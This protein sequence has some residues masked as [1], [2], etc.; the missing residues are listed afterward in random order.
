M[1]FQLFRAIALTVVLCFALPAA[2]EGPRLCSESHYYFSGR[3]TAYSLAEGKNG[4]A[5]EKKVQMS[6]LPEHWNTD[7]TK[8]E[9]IVLSGSKWQPGLLVDLALES[10]KSKQVFKK[11]SKKVAADGSIGPF[12][13]WIDVQRKDPR[14]LILTLRLNGQELCR[15]KVVF[16]ATE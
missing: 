7:D 14:V 9:S 13:D 15:Q 2:A 16:D 3:Y 5:L 6:A 1:T 11:E 4:R 8:F 12:S 10:Q